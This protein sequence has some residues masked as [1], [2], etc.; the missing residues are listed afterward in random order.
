MAKMWETDTG[1]EELKQYGVN[2]MTFTTIDYNGKLQKVP[3]SVTY[4]LSKNKGV[5][6][7]MGVKSFRTDENNPNILIEGKSYRTNPQT[8]QAETPFNTRYVLDL[9]KAKQ[10]QFR[11]TPAPTSA[12]PDALLQSGN[13]LKQLSS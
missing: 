4:S 5:L 1:R 6:E 2:S 10:Q 13:Q 12:S 7:N 8:G 3:S 11:N 9:N